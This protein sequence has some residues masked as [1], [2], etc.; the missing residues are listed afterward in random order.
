MKNKFAIVVPM[1]YNITDGTNASEFAIHRFKTKKAAEEYQN[2]IR[3]QFA[4]LVEVKAE[5]GT[6]GRKKRGKD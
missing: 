6:A 2:S 5:Y 3:W 4:L 1:K